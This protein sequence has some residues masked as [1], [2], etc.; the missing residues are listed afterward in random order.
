M[1]HLR[2][3]PVL[4]IVGFLLGVTLTLLAALIVLR[5]GWTPALKR[6]VIGS[7]AF[8]QATLQLIMFMHMTEG[9]DRDPK[10]VHTIYAVGM[11]IVIVIGS[12]WVMTAGHPIY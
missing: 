12:I 5:T 6:T 1:R 8:I 10:V 3:I 7:F 2:N 11:A 9:G 4:H